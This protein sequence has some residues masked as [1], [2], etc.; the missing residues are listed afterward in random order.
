MGPYLIFQLGGGAGGI[1]GI[2]LHIGKANLEDKSEEAVKELEVYADF[3]QGEVDKEMENRSPE[4]GKT[5]ESLRM[6]RDKLLIK[7]LKEHKKI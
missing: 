6:F 2:T 1:K 5:N 3:I 4:F 7:I